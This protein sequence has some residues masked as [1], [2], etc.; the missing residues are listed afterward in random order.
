MHQSQHVAQEVVDEVVVVRRAE[1]Q[2]TTELK[3]SETPLLPPHHHLATTHGP[4]PLWQPHHP[5]ACQHQPYITNNEFC[6]RQNF[7]YPLQ[8]RGSSG[9]GPAVALGR[10]AR[11][12]L[13][14]DFAES[15]G[16]SLSTLGL[17]AATMA[18]GLSCRGWC[19][20][21]EVL[22]I[23]SEDRLTRAGLTNRA[24][25]HSGSRSWCCRMNGMWCIG[26]SDEGLVLAMERNRAK[27][28]RS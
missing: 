24:R 22:A 8:S 2:Q 25:F 20:G 23:I 17:K 26:S 12:I 4:G 5:Q 13:V 7:E 11:E 10:A 6:T 15:G 18:F 19:R 28:G 9:F 21:E 1:E 27:D 16:R 3:R 14:R